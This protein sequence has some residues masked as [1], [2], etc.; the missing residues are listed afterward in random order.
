[1]QLTLNILN[2]SSSELELIEALIRSRR[3]LVLKYESPSEGNV[4]C[5]STQPE[6][7]QPTLPFDG[8]I[9]TTLSPKEVKSDKKPRAKRTETVSEAPNTPKEVC[10][11]ILP[12][13][14][15]KIALQEVKELAQAMVA[16][17]DRESVKAIISVYGEKLTEVKE[18][19][20][21]NLFNALNALND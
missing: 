5:I 9:D 18:S 11:D 13:V 15:R 2:M 17:H 14:K 8:E 16:K 7:N 6:S 1:M 10:G 21:Q 19:D 12:E 3:N 4:G 20:Y